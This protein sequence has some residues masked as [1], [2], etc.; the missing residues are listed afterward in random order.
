MAS[1][2]AGKEEAQTSEHPMSEP[3]YVEFFSISFLISSQLSLG[4]LS[5]SQSYSGKVR[6]GYCVSDRR[7]SSAT[8][9]VPTAPGFGANAV[10]RLATH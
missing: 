4:V 1:E 3:E 8:R 7:I 2:M 9:A 5:A 10:V 6:R